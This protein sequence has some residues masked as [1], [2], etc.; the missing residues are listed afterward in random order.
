MPNDKTDMQG[1]V[2]RELTRH[3]NVSQAARAANV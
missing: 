3:G 1:F 2:L